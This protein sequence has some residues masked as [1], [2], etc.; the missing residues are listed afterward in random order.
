MSS[1]LS[2]DYTKKEDVVHFETTE[3][4]QDPLQVTVKLVEFFIVLNDK[5]QL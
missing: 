2:Q 5:H 1:H 4:F 3:D